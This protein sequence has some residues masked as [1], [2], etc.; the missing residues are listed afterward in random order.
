MHTWRLIAAL[1]LVL[2]TAFIHVPPAQD[3]SRYQIG[4]VAGKVE[5]VP[6]MNRFGGPSSWIVENPPTY[7]VDA[8]GDNLQVRVQRLT[9][10][11]RDDVIITLSI[12]G[13]FAQVE[14]WSDVPPGKIIDVGG[15]ACL[16][17]DGIKA[18]LDFELGY[19]SC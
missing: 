7:S 5:D 3:S 18:S 14:Y 19:K 10:F 17:T 8:S 16:A 4:F 11:Q 6:T 1:T 12:D 13:A 9:A 15:V 2:C